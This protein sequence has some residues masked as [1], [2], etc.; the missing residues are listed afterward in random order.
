MRTAQILASGFVNR[1]QNSFFSYQA[2]PSVCRD[3]AGT[4]YAGA[5]S[6]FGRSLFIILPRKRAAGM[7]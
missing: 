4:L 2:W 5:C 3:E 7:V 6:Q 1:T